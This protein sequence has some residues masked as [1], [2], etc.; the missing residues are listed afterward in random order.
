MKDSKKSKRTSKKFKQFALNNSFAVIRV[1]RYRFVD[2]S[3]RIFFEVMGDKSVEKKA[4]EIEQICNK[5]GYK[6]L[7]I[8]FKDLRN[9]Q[10]KI[11]N[12]INSLKDITKPSSNLI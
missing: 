8:S 10:D 2:N 3:N 7:A 6:F 5:H 1:G 12:N 9:H 11:I 4:K